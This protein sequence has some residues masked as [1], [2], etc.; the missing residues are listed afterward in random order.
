MFME[1]QFLIYT[2]EVKIVLRCK[3]QIAK[4]ARSV[5]SPI[6]YNIDLWFYFIEEFS[7]V[8]KKTN[9]VEET[10]TRTLTLTVVNGKESGRKKIGVQ[11]MEMLS[12]NRKLLFPALYRECRCHRHHIF[13]SISSIVSFFLRCVRWCLCISIVMVTA[14]ALHIPMFNWYAARI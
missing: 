8:T 13:L 3:I 5:C 1:I 10:D 9:F 11:Y 14:T 4:C 2:Q 12:T 7:V 6:V